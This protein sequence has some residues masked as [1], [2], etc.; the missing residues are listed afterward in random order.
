MPASYEKT[1]ALVPIIERLIGSKPYHADL[2]N[3]GIS[4]QV[5]FYH[6]EEQLK[7]R[8][9]PAYAYVKATNIK[10]RALGQ[11]DATIVVDFASWSKMNEARRVALVDHE[12]YH[13]TIKKDKDMANEFDDLGR[14]KIKMRKHDIEFGWFVEI[15]QEHK[16]DSIEVFQ[17]TQ[18]VLSHKQTLFAFAL[19]DRPLEPAQDA[20][21]VTIKAG[22]N[23]PVTITHAQFQKL[24]K[25]IKTEADAIAK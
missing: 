8:G 15:A 19:E 3:T 4:V 5:L 11:K 14:P 12:L 13:L 9:M 21:T 23:E 7:H 18:L 25:K 16:Q 22:D 20:S 6:D 10:E 24:S 17:A 1:N 2:N